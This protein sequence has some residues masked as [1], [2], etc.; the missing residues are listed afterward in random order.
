MSYEAEPDNALRFGD[1]VSGYVL[2]ASSIVPCPHE[3]PRS[4]HIDVERPICAVVLSPCCSIGDRTLTLTPLVAPLGKFFDNPYLAEDLTRANRL[5]TPKQSV[6]PDVWEAMS[7]NDKEARFDFDQPL[8]YAFVDHFVYAPHELLPECKVN[9]K[10]GKI[11]TG[12][13]MID[14]RRLYKIQCDGIQSAKQ[15]P[16]HT[17]ILQLSIATRQELRDKLTHYFGRVPAEDAV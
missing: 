3:H 4:Y 7:A 16:L 14:F 11:T 6:P 13:H 1:V 8:S 17:K 9:K 12:F 10:G 2:S 5:M 15:A